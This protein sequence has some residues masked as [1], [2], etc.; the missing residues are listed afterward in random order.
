MRDEPEMTICFQREMS[1]EDEGSRG[2]VLLDTS[3]FLDTRRA[4]EGVQGEGAAF[5]PPCPAQPYRDLGGPATTSLLP[6]AFSQQLQ[7]GFFHLPRC[8]GV[9]HPPGLLLQQ[10]GA[11]TFLQVLLPVV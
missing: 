1:L 3:S 11:D 2:W 4:G 6:P 5:E 7:L 9:A 10:F 8:F